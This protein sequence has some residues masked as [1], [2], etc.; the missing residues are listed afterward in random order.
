MVE[1]S[2]HSRTEQKHTKKS[3]E[4]KESIDMNQESQEANQSSSA[5]VWKFFAAF[6]IIL[7]IFV[8]IILWTK[9]SQASE[10]TKNSYNGFDFTPAQGGLWITRIDVRKQP[11]DIP[12]YFHPRDTEDI[13][14][15]GN[16]TQPIMRKPAQVVIS[17]DPNEPSKVVVG[18]VEVARIIGTKYNI[19]NIPTSS[20]LSK[21]S[22]SKV[23]IPIL[24]C[25]NATSDMV[26]VE[27]KKGRTNAIGTNGNCVVI[28]YTD[29]NESVRVA[30]RYAYM[31][32]KIM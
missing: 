30:D 12:F 8:G 1:K 15:E 32:L 26:V 22:A 14:I 4:I 23:D 29:A 31:L 13:I 10:K 6:A 20:A 17:I 2:K 28:Q 21:P 5:G 11:Y 25:A 9:Y 24:S 3:V 18:G 19:Y 7:I 16:V 27:F